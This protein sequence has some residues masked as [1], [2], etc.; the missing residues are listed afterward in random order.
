MV[1]THVACASVILLMS[2]EC[3]RTRTGGSSAISPT[4]ISIT[5]AWLS[6]ARVKAKVVSPGHWTLTTAVCDYI[7]RLRFH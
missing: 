5:S 3:I 1:R 6:I 7:N 2:E 4:S